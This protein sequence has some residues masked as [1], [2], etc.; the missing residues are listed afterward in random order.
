M[1]KK[2]KYQTPIEITVELNGESYSGSYTT[3]AGII[4]VD[5]PFGMGT[6]EDKTGHEDLW[7]KVRLRELIQRGLTQDR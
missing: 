2:N 5:S 1:K 4:R 7:A 6:I 3:H